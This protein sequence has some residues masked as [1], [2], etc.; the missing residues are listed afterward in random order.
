M[1]LVTVAAGEDMDQVT[2]QDSVEGSECRVPIVVVLIEDGK[3]FLF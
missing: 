1:E 3:M 2:E